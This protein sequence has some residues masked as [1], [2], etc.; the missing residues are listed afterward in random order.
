[1]GKNLRI[2]ISLLAVILGA[3]AHKSHVFEVVPDTFSV[4]AS[5]MGS[6]SNQ[7]TYLLAREKAERWCAERSLNVEEKKRYDTVWGVGIPPATTLYFSC[8]AEEKKVPPQLNN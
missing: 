7:A 6:T 8:S 1:M 5:K 4:S 2:S 3:C